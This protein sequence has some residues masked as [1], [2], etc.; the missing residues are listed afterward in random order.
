MSKKVLI[1]QCFSPP[2]LLQFG[3][4]R[5]M[6]VLKFKI[7]SAEAKDDRREIRPSLKRS[8]AEAG[9]PVDAAFSAR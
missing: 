6:Y 4:Q 1:L 8:V 7:R 5:K 9:A 3:L 2:G